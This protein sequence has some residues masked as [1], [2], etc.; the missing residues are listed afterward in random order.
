MVA[1]LGIGSIWLMVMLIC[2]ASYCYQDVKEN[3]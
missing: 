2:V 3:D 1:V